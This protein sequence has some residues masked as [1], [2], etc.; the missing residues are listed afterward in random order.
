MCTEKVNNIEKKKPKTTHIYNYLNDPAY[1]GEPMAEVIASNKLWT[2]T[3]LTARHGML[4]CGKNFKGTIPEICQTCK[5][6]DNENHR[7]NE[8]IKW[9]NFN[10][11]GGETKLTSMRCTAVICKSLLTL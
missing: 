7:L 1:K 8:C 2:K 6:E 9:N 4:E 10:S 11:S 5:K 3:I